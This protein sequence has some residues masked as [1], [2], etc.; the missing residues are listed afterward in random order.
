MITVRNKLRE[1]L[2]KGVPVFG[3]FSFSGSPRMVEMMGYAGLDYIIIDTEHASDDVEK[4][5]GL[6]R[7]AEVSGTVPIIRVYRNEPS[8]IMKA[9]DV[10]AMGVYVPHVNSRDDA[11]QA[12]QAAKYPPHGTRGVCPRIRAAGYS[13]AS[14]NQFYKESNEQTMVWVIIEEERGVKNIEEIASVPGVDVIGIGTADLSQNMKQFGE[15]RSDEILRMTEHACK[16]CKQ[17]GIAFKLGGPAFTWTERFSYE[18]WIR[19]MEKWREMGALVFGIGAGE[20]VLYHHFSQLMRNV[21]SDLHI[22]S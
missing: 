14:W 13:A 5:E 11:V 19:D 20:S 1:K 15:Y 18:D 17:N 12:V 16:I 10:G 2:S 22:A 7:A 4:A 9:L 8:L 21:K 3:V 6:V